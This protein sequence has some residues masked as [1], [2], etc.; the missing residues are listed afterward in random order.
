MRQIVAWVGVV[1]GLVAVAPSAAAQ[2]VEPYKGKATG[3]RVAVIGDSITF[4]TKEEIHAWLDP[5]YYVSVDGRSGFTIAQQLSVA[6]VYAGQT[7][8]PSIVVVN[9]G[10][11]DM[12]Q[13]VPVWASGYD[14]GSMTGKFPSAKCIVLVD[15][16][17]NT[18]N[19]TWNAWAAQFN[20]DVI[21]TAA[22][23]DARVRV[24]RWHR[25]VRDYFSAGQPYGELTTD[26]VHPTEL[27]QYFLGSMIKDQVNVCPR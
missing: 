23:W 20:Q 10:T 8:K 7:P 15:I 2:T 5:N 12:T 21:Y 19:A 17:G 11:N 13:A 3:P 25:F 27:G 14:L 9:L 24:V 18:M 22:A 16:N 1:S 4:L 26:M 6:T